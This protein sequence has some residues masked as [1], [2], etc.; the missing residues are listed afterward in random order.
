MNQAMQT[1]DFKKV[2]KDLYAP[3]QTPMRVFVPKM[4]FIA[5]QGEG[6]PNDSGGA[7]QEALK[8][9][10]A[11]S[12]AIKMDKGK[13]FQGYFDYVVP[14]LESLWWGNGDFKDKD[15]FQWQAMIAQPDF[16]TQAIF[17]WAC[18]EVFRKKNLDCNR[19]SFISFEEGLCVQMLHIGAYDDEPKS[20][21]LIEDFIT[22]SSLCSDIGG[23]KDGLLRAHHEIYLNNPNKTTP[24]K[25]KT[26]LRIPVRE[27]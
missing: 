3:K 19:A 12:Y 4:S 18:D 6:N 25:L 9:L 13:K 20:L 23:I 17:E 5:V 15:N 2:F 27:S 8:V 24:Q 16:M 14:P 26:I 7:Y 11:L 1:F 10:Y 22:H 21:A